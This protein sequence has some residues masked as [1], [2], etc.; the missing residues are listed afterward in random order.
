MAQTHPS[1][2]ATAGQALRCPRKRVSSTWAAGPTVRSTA[3]AKNAPPPLTAARLLQPSPHTRS[4]RPQTP[5]RSPQRAN[6]PPRD[7][8]LGRARENL[9]PTPGLGTRLG[10]RNEIGPH[11]GREDCP[12][13]TRKPP[14]SRRFLGWRDPDS[15][16]GHHDFQPCGR[17]SRTP[18][19]CLQIRRCA[20]AARAAGKSQI[21][22]FPHRLGR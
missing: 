4:P 10:T 12:S 20:H 17:R 1:C 19:N 16:R 6:Q 13:N 14:A 7:L 2:P 21:P 11:S 9:A 3:T 8:H 18:L 15:N 22:F 5:D